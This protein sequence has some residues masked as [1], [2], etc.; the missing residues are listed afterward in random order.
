MAAV[1]PTPAPGFHFVPATLS[2]AKG[3]LTSEPLRLGSIGPHQPAL[4]PCRGWCA[5][6]YFN[7]LREL[8]C[9]RRIV[10]DEVRDRTA[11]YGT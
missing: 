10:E 8:G 6:C 2:G 11:R 4:L 5:L 3:F 1:P 9:A 7:A